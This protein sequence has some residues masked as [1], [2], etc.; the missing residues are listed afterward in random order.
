MII[1]GSVLTIDPT[2]TKWLKIITDEKT[3]AY[4]FYFHGGLKIDK[5]KIPHGILKQILM[6]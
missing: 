6:H 1:N 4:G 2:D 5:V 3:P